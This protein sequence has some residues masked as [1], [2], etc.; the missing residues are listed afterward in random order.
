MLKLFEFLRPIG[1]PGR[2]ELP[3]HGGS[4]LFN[5]A[6]WS[7]AWVGEIVHT[8]PANRGEGAGGGQKSRNQP[9]CCRNGDN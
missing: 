2:G 4:I 5:E 8:R 3:Q 7:S 1:T 9:G 6:D